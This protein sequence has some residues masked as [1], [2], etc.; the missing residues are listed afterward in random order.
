[1]TILRNAFE[2]E[3]GKGTLGQVQNT[4]VDNG[5]TMYLHTSLGGA[6][7]GACEALRKKGLKILFICYKRNK[8]IYL[9]IYLKR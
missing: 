5:L 9:F 2:A 4:L 1:M 7:W 8:F 6:V 3:K